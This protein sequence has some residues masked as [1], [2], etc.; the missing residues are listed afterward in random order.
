[1]LM[2]RK[3]AH[4]AILSG[5]RAPRVQHENTPAD[6]GLD[7]Q[8]VR[9]K[10]PTGKTLFAWFVP[11]I[12]GV[13]APAVLVMHGWGSN[14]SMMLP[15]AKPM[16]AAG[17]A[18][19]LMDARCHG[20]SD[21]EEFTSL[22]RFAE[23]IEAGLGWLKQ[24]SGVNPGQLAVIGHSVGAGAA[25]LC[26]SRREDLC[27][28]VSLS[29]FAHPR[30]V[31]RGYL[32]AYRIPYAIVGW[33]VLQHVQNVIGKRFEDI[34]PINT[35]SRTRCPVLLV[36]GTEDETVP[37]NDVRRIHTAAPAGMAQCLAIPGGHDL[38]HS[39]PDHIAQVLFF[40]NQAFF[41]EKPCI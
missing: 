32:A 33:Y 1:M 28:V 9:I 5:L 40:L 39:L 25:L 23:D 34:A 27:A 17:Y 24:Q 18:V 7:A 6:L 10:G 37:F 38:S 41:P 29:A 4:R 31:M 21:D 8:A 14:A 22:P 13:N 35:V 20:E 36:H 2:L 19:L 16:H 15:A 12:G 26:A 11:A 30:E 3:G